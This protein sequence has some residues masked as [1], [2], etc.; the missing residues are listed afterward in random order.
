M[1]SMW[2]KVRTRMGAYRRRYVNG[3]EQRRRV[4]WPT[5]E[6]PTSGR[7][8]VVIVS[9]NTRELTRHTLWSLFSQLGRQVDEVVVVDNGSDDGSLEDLQSA[10]DRGAITLAKNKGVPQHGPGI[11]CALSML[12]ARPNSHEIGRVWILDSDVVVLRPDTLQDALRAME[13]SGAAM[14]GERRLDGDLLL[15][16]SVVIDPAKVWIAQNPVFRWDGL[17]SDELQRDL[18]ERGQKT[19][20]FPF[21]EGRYLL[22][23]GGGT[24]RVLADRGASTGHQWDPTYSWLTDGE[25][26][27]AQELARFRADAGRLNAEEFGLRLASMST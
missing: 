16:C 27:Y 22:H 1:S 12:A 9:F 20:H 19:A 4:P 11:N 17:P 24:L 7:T 23:V 3:R 14:V 18:Q 25:A 15:L 13:S 2:R 8:V 5:D 10:A 6:S 26:V 21:S